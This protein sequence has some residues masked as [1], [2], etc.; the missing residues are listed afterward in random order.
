MKAGQNKY[1]S[2][3]TLVSKLNGDELTTHHLV[4]FFPLMFA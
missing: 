2:Q 4:F 1:Y 3:D